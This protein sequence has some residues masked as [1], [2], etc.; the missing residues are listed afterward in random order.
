MESALAS[1]GFASRNDAD[2]RIAGALTMTDEKTLGRA[3]YAQEKKALFI[4]RV[5]FVVE[6]DTGFVAED[7][8]RLLKRNPM[9][10]EVRRSFGWIPIKRDH[11]HSVWTMGRFASNDPATD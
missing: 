8:S 1:G 2:K 9:F 11:L 6:L 3:A 5:R 4:C 10:A 7:R